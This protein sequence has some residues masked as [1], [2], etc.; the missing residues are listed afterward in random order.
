MPNPAG[1]QLALKFYSDKAEEIDI[2]MV[3]HGGK[4]VFMQKQ[5][6]VKGNNVI[7]ITNLARFSNG[8]YMMQV[9]INNNWL[10]QNFILFN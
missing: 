6:A 3:D 10:T 1:S 4:I 8:A 7:S 2:R 5:K 9:L